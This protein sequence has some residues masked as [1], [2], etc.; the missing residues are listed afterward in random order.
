MHC[1]TTGLNIYS[2]SVKPSPFSEASKHHSDRRLTRIF[3]FLRPRNHCSHQHIELSRTYLRQLSCRSRLLKGFHSS[4]GR[5]ST[6]RRWRFRYPGCA[7]RNTQDG[8]DG[9]RSLL[10][11]KK[12][13]NNKNSSCFR[14]VLSFLFPQCA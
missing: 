7:C 8:L 10:E 6:P 11:K 14:V 2:P 13:T 5:S 9:N 12:Q 3:K 1:F 4:P